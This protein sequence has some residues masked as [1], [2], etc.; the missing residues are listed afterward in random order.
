MRSVLGVL[1]LGSLACTPI[2]VVTD[3]DPDTDFSR[4]SS[5]AQVPPPAESPALPNYSRALGARIQQ[6]IASLL[7][8]KGYRAAR[9]EQADLRVAFHVSD[10]SRERLVV[11]PDPDANYQVLEPYLE[12]TLEIEV[13]DARSG[14]RVWHGHGQSVILTSG[15]LVREN[16]DS[17]ALEEVR[18]MLKKF[19]AAAN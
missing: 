3:A 17:V 2:Q 13:V 16:V 9:P 5:Y 14:R 15:R 11:A 4:F 7:D 10:T 12:G 8:A 1:L 18:A 6:E 19:P